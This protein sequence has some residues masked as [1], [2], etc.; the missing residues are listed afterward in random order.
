MNIILKQLVTA[1]RLR[2]DVQAFNVGYQTF[3]H[4]D[5]FPL[6]Y[7][8]K[9][10]PLD[11]NTL[12][13]FEYKWLRRFDTNEPLPPMIVVSDPHE[14]IAEE[15]FA[16]RTILLATG[17]TIVRLFVYL[18]EILYEMGSST[19][20]LVDDIQQLL[21][22]QSTRQIIECAFILLKNPII[23]T[24][25]KQKIIEHADAGVD[26]GPL[27][28]HMLELQHM[29]YGAPAVSNPDLSPDNFLLPLQFQGEY[30]GDPPEMICKRL[31]IQGN[32][33]GYLYVVGIHNSFT[34][35][36]YNLINLVG[37]LV[38]A[39]MSDRLCSLLGR[40]HDLRLEDLLRDILDNARSEEYIVQKCAQISI[41]KKQ[42]LYTIIIC[43][44]NTD[45]PSRVS[46]YELSVRF[47]Q[48]LP[49]CTGLLYRNSILL[50]LGSDEEITDFSSV[51]APILADMHE[52]H[53]IAG[54]SGSFS[55]LFK[56][57]EARHQAMKAMQ[58]GY[59][60]NPKS[61][62]YLYRDY[63]IYHMIELSGHNTDLAA[64]C[65]P[66]VIRLLSYCT[67]KNEYE[68]LDTLKV[69]I[70]C[71]GNRSQISREMYIHLNTVKYRLKRIQ[72]IMGIDLTNNENV[73]KIMLSLKTIEYKNA[74][75]K[76]Q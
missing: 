38:A 36:D 66:E 23:I 26:S 8:A 9:P 22:C 5:M 2:T 52:L 57:R 30:E 56:L 25:H 74:T 28:Q 70:K 68:L 16:S 35:R 59:S 47:S 75:S 13:V 48:A 51:L 33:V 11:E 53:L 49:F 32:T 61:Y 43:V 14:E 64:F 29:P 27:Y 55:D 18:T 34:A 44:R 69:Y 71:G 40:E 6:A 67:Q 58:L 72:E 42:Y 20:T 21:T 73:L 15:F 1:L 60:I 12:Y 4:I 65:I 17:I 63:F 10:T 31:L 62:I 46:L 3:S 24:D 37:N 54:I 45:I 7:D 41:A 39:S 19:S 50:L 76:L